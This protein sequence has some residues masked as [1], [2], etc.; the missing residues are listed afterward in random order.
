MFGQTGP[1]VKEYRTAAQH[2]LACEGLFM[3]CCDI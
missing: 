3:A 2:F 1:T